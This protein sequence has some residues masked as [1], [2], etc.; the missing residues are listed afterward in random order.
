MTNRP[1]RQCVRDLKPKDSVDEI[2]LLKSI[3][4]QES[5]D[6]KKYLNIILADATG[7]V[8]GRVWNIAEEMMKNVDRGDYVKCIGKV[9]FFQGRRQVNIN[10]LTKISSAQINKEDFILK[11]KENPEVMFQELLEIVESMND[12]YLKLLLQYVLGDEEIARRLKTWQAGKSVHHAYQSG[13]LEHILSSTILGTTLA[14]HYGV[15]HNYVIAG[16]ILHDICKIYELSDGVNVEYTEEGKLVGHLVKGVELLDRFAYRIKNFPHVM[17][18]HL[19]HILVAHHGEYAFGSPKLPSTSEAYLVHII[20]MMDSKMNAFEMSKR[21]DNSSG[22]WTGYIKHLDRVIYKAEL[23]FYDQF[24][25]DE[26][27]VAPHVAHSSKS[28]VPNKLGPGKELK[29]NLGD[30]LGGIKITKD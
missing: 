10:E 22:N 5:K 29:Q 6:G 27:S 2:F 8:E 11:S 19:K 28:Q 1:D 9:N 21:M 30:L 18:M 17:K 26:T 20:D 15:N 3:T 7:D 12:V 23:P 13:L 25:E 14:R 24:I 4:M 16:N